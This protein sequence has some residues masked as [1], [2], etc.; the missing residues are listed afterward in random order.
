MISVLMP[1]CRRGVD[2]SLN[3]SGQAQGTSYNITYL[4]G[5]Y[6][7]YRESIDS[8][9]KVIDAS[10]STY[11]PSSLIS[12]INA[13]DSS[14]PV[15]EHF[16][17]VF[18]KSIQVST[19][20][21]GLFDITVA[22]L[23]NAYGFG[24]S[25]K[26]TLDPQTLDSLRRWIGYGKVS[27]VDRKLVKT[28]PQVKLDFNAIAQGYTVDVLAGFLESKGIHNY[29]IEL[30]G[31]IRAKGRKLDNSP[32]TLGIEQPDEDQGN[33]AAIQSTIALA[34]QSLATSGNY[35]KFYV[36]NGKKYTHIINPLTGLPAKNNL[37]SATVVAPDCMTADAYATSFIVMG[38][39][40]AK[41]FV[42]AHSELD[43]EVFFIYDDNGTMKTYRSNNFPSPLKASIN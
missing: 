23:I 33:G 35:K 15:D 29:L 32:W 25:R 40:K 12:R 9:F 20:T 37:L 21:G 26:R 10:L 38:M 19:S 27:I 16:E 43:L 31:E 30:G 2:T 5:A 34:D 11:V 18:V 1:A 17:R 13:N 42:N 4:A 22:P 41:E 3:I 7:N 39:E 36:E 8:I 6:S 28:Y 24:P 14:L